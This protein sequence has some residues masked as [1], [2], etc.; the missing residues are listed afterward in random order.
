MSIREYESDD[1]Q[2]IARGYRHTSDGGMNWTEES[3]AVYHT[4]S[5]KKSYMRG[6]DTPNFRKLRDSGKLLPATRFVQWSISGFTTGDRE[7]QSIPVPASLDSYAFYAPYS[8]WQLTEDV[9]SAIP[10]DADGEARALVQAAAAAIASQ[11]FDG[12]TFLAEISKTVSLFRG[13]LKRLLGYI[14]SGKIHKIWLEGRY[15]WRLVVYDIIA[16]NELLSNLDTSPFDRHKKRFSTSYTTTNHTERDDSNPS[17][18]RTIVVDDRHEV[19]ITGSV[20]A[21]IKPPKIVFDSTKT[22]WELVPFSF[23]VDWFISVGNF[24]DSLSFL[25]MATDHVAWYGIQH[26]VHRNMELEFS[27]KPTATYTSTTTQSGECTG[28]YTIRV[29]TSIPSLPQIRTNLNTF[30][31]LDLV[32]LLVQAVSK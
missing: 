24:L 16:I 2:S 28:V 31:V 21:D 3:P 1:P 25:R 27:T 9:L 17:E 6:Y 14:A 20:L 18:N 10:G 29:P 23:V 32:A 5:I 30:K 22:A 12:G 4:S 15:G 13:A 19:S 7:N 11:G 26:T 8:D